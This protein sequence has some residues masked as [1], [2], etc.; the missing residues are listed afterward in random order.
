MRRQRAADARRETVRWSTIATAS[1]SRTRQIQAS[2]A[3]NEPKH[4]DNDQEQTKNA[5]DP[6]ASVA[7]MGVVSSA[8]KEKNQ[9]KDD[10]NRAHD[11]TSSQFLIAPDEPEAS[12]TSL[13]G[14]APRR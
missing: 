9:D 6:G 1:K 4:H 2:E 12:I 3:T 13:R 10:K 5:S 7:V 14:L 8:A 11:N